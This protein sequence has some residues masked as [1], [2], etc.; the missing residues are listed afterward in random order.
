MN[1]PWGE[2][3]HIACDR[4]VHDSSPK[5]RIRA[6]GIFEGELAGAIRSDDIIRPYDHA[7]FVDMRVV[8]HA[9]IVDRSPDEDGERERRLKS[10]VCCLYVR[11]Y[12]AFD[13]GTELE[14]GRRQTIKRE[15]ERKR[16]GGGGGS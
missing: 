3:H 6:A 11:E 8:R 14:E 2:E 12:Q 10:R 15:R 1:D 9:V 13:H 5:G 16:G 4:F 7:V